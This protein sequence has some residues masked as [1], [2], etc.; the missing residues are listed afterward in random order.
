[1][2]RRNLFIALVLFAAVSSPVF[3]QVDEPLISLRRGMLWHSFYYA[4][5]ALPFSNWTRISYGLD[6]PGYDPE[7]IG[8]PIGG[9]TSYMTTG[10]MWIT[11]KDDSGRIISVED[12]AMY[13]GTVGVQG[14]SKYQISKHARRWPRGENFWLQANPAEAQEVIDTEWERNPAYVPTYT[15]DR[16]LPLNVKRTVRQWA[17]SQLDENYIIV[18]Y[19]MKNISPTD[20][21]RGTH[22]MLSYALSP[23]YRGWSTLFANLNAGARN[24]RFSYFPSGILSR[25]MAAFADDYPETP[26]S[27]SRP[28]EK[29]DFYKDGGPEG[30]GEFLAPG[31]VGFR[32]LYSS[33]DSSG[34]ASR[35][36]KS[37]WSAAP[38]DQDLYGPFGSASAGL[39]GRYNIVRDPSFASE[40]FT[41]ATDTRMTRRR[42]WSLLSLGP[43]TLKPGD[44]IKV[45]VAE[46][47]AGPPYALA[48]D[49]AANIG[50]S[51]QTALTTIPVRAMLAYNNNYNIP[52]VP[53]SPEFTIEISTDPG[54]ISN[55][56]KWKND[57]EQ[58]ADPDY[59][60]AEAKDFAGY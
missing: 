8:A 52:D 47:V 19:K 7:W 40:S 32:L 34:T 25:T 10:G 24:T 2:S 14:G 16:A 46:F 3:A 37:V 9:P 39:E 12:W 6:W 57:R 1:M 21:M 29:F 56:L 45:V 60:G 58:I 42:L 51:A 54:K 53:P 36:S 31:Y 27:D 55:I 13:A 28:S 4:K 20:T 26:V 30:K 18:E 49:P 11:A 15:G 38:N 5:D 43:W 44:T 48:I 23:N 22:I 50:G 35:V 59:S 17:G 33:P 41:S